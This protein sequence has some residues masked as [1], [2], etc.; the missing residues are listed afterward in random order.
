MTKGGKL[1]VRELQGLLNASYQPTESVEGF[2]IDNQLSTK[3][4]KVYHKPETGQTVV[5]HRGTSGFTDWFNNAVYAYGGKNYYQYTSRY[6][7]AKSIQEKAQKKYGLDNITTIRY[8][9]AGTHRLSI[10]ACTITGVI[11]EQQSRIRMSSY[12]PPV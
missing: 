10:H 7:E 12:V 2:R 4:S 1:K 8:R 3:T 5:A 11:S 6:R 9:F